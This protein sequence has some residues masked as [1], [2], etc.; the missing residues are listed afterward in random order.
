MANN[1]RGN[2]KLTKGVVLN[3]HGRPKGTLNKRSEKWNQLCDYLL[4]DGIDRLQ[5]AMSGLEP[6]EFIDAYVKILA[7]IK[8]KLQSVDT[9]STEGI[10][11]II[12]NETNDEQS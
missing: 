4:D 12:Q 11:I 1:P 3:P 6:K 7:Y 10:K 2:P 8:P 5:N 9:N